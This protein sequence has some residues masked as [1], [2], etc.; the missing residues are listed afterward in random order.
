MKDGMVLDLDMENEMFSN[1]HTEEMLEQCNRGV[2]V[3]EFGHALGFLHEH[4]RSD[5]PTSCPDC[6][7]FEPGESDKTTGKWDLMSIM[8]YCFPD[9]M[10]VYPD[11]LSD[12]DKVGLIQMYPPPKVTSPATPGDDDDDTGPKTQLTDEDDSITGDDDDAA[13]DDDKKSSSKKKS[14]SRASSASLASSGCS[15]APGSAPPSV[16]ASGPLLGFG[17]VLAARRRR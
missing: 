5:T 15:S 11:G 2:A 14:T 8:N 9:R 16:S 17:L 10:E 6:N 4:E 1:C 3:H 12:L 7:P 13:S